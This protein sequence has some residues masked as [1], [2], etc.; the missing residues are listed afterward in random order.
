MGICI[1]VYM[2]VNKHNAFS[3]RKC[4][5]DNMYMCHLYCVY[6]QRCIICMYIYI[7]SIYVY[8]FI[9]HVFSFVYQ[10][11][12]SFIHLVKLI[13]YYLTHL[14]VYISLILYESICTC[15]QGSR[16]VQ[17]PRN[18]PFFHV[19]ENHPVAPLYR[20]AVARKLYMLHAPR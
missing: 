13:F 10:F 18:E 3:I 2:Y 1:Y 11:N 6:S 8:T 7:I 14:I 4:K 19:W 5:Y 17:N 20:A 12:Y 15:M 16:T 9:F